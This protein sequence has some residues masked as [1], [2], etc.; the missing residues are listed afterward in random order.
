M[1][2]IKYAKQFKDAIMFPYG[3]DEQFDEECDKS[4]SRALDVIY[5]VSILAYAV[6]AV[7]LVAVLIS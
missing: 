1:K 2:V 5:Y 6:Y 4:F 7:T 3:V